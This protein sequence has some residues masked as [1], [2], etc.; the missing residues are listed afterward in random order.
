MTINELKE[1]GFELDESIFKA[2]YEDPRLRDLPRQVG[3]YGF[4]ARYIVAESNIY[5]VFGVN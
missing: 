2:I 1:N 4:F 5:F 3:L